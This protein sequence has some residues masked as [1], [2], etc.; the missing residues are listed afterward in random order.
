MRLV[1]Y[2]VYM[3]QRVHQL[4]INGRIHH[5]N[6]KNE[7]NNGTI[8][9]QKMKMKPPVT[10]FQNDKYCNEKFITGTLGTLGILVIFLLSPT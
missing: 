9:L 2:N 10:E 1:T 3:L 6:F 4:S 5:N 8:E 7:M